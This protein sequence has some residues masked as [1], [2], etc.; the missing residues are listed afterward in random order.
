M[1]RRQVE[2]LGQIVTEDV[3]AY[4]FTGRVAL[5]EGMAAF[6][7]RYTDAFWTWSDCRVVPQQPDDD[8]IQVEFA[9]SRYWT[10]EDG[11]VY[12]TDALDVLHLN[13]GDLKIKVRKGSRVCLG[14]PCRGGVGMHTPL[15][16]RSCDAAGHHV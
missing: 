10:G 13:P 9:F 7:A 15:T 3:T 12:R 2:L 16:H 1:C 8:V 14:L 6:H 4:G 5:L 11:R